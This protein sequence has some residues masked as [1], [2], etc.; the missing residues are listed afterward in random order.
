M[1]GKTKFPIGMFL[2]ILVGKFL[3]ILAVPLLLLALFFMPRVLFDLSLIELENESDS[4]PAH[5]VYGVLHTEKESVPVSTILGK[6]SKDYSLKEIL[7]VAEQQAYFVYCDSTEDCIWRVASID[8][9]TREIADLVQFKDVHDGNYRPNYTGQ[10]A[11]RC[12]YFHDGK[13]VL[14][15]K[16]RVLIYDIRDGTGTITDYDTYAFPKYE[17]NGD[18][19]EEQKFT[20]TLQEMADKSENF[21][22]IHVM[23][24]KTTW[25]GTARSYESF[26]NRDLYAV[27]GKIYTIESILNYGGEAHMFIFEYDKDND[28][29][30]YVSKCFAGDM[31]S[32]ECYIIPTVT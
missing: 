7:C 6:Q 12:G 21:A 1:K 31:V 24:N 25:D 8:L 9:E 3:I 28:R 19:T 11:D 2:V 32:R 26:G 29:W 18:D 16:N 13:I 14:N 17:V 15:D 5:V 30:L 20:F 22:R 10:Y 23:G 27:D 4:I